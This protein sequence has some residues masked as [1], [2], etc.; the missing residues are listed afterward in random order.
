[1]LEITLIDDGDEAY[2]GVPDG[3]PSAQ[4]MFETVL[5]LP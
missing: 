4:M 5:Q 2:L 3:Q 1:M